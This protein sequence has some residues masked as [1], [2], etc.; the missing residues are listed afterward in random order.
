MD[1]LPLRLPSPQEVQNNFE[2]GLIS[3]WLF[4]TTTDS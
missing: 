3:Q 4:Y 1:I 2:E